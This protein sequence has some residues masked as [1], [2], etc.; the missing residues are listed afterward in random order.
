MPSM[1]TLILPEPR[2]A[3]LLTIRPWCTL[4]TSHL[5]TPDFTP[6]SSCPVVGPER[7]RLGV[8]KEEILQDL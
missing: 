7:G 8:G 4:P 1:E 5:I 3:S 2:S 6:V